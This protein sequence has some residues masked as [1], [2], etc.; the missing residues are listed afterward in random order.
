MKKATL[1]MHRAVTFEG[2]KAEW[3]IMKEDEVVHV[4]DVAFVQLATRNSSLSGLI[5][6]PDKDFHCLSRS[7]GYQ[8]LMQLRNKEARRLWEEP[9]KSSST[10]FAPVASPVRRTQTRDELAS[11]R[12]QHRCL[13]IKLSVGEEVHDVKL[14][15]PV[16]PRDTMFVAFEETSI[17]VVLHHIQTKGFSEQ[18]RPRNVESLPKGVHKHGRG[19]IV[20]YTDPEGYTRR[21][22]KHKL[23]DA[24]KFHADPTIDD[25]CEENDDDDDAEPANEACE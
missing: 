16:H 10:L 18:K 25:V 6:K 22:L 14:L 8:E 24:L 4:D 2:S 11:Q 21:R 19:Y 13:T 20:M 23:A 15:R 1:K 9:A 5:G 12:Q 3:K 17:S 7:I